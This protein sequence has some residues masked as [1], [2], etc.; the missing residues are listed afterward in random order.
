[1][2]GKTKTMKTKDGR[3]I[4]IIEPENKFI[5][6]KPTKKE[7]QEDRAKNRPSATEQALSD[8]LSERERQK[9]L[10]GLE[11]L[12]LE[13][14]KAIESLIG[15]PVYRRSEGGA[16]EL[17]MKGALTGAGL[18]KIYGKSKIKVEKPKGTKGK[19]SADTLTGKLVR[20]Y[21]VKEKEQMKKKAKDSVKASGLGTGLGE[22]FKVYPSAYKKT[23]GKP[24]NKATGGKIELPK[25]AD[26]DGDGNFNEYETA[27]GEAIQK[28]MAKEKVETASLG[29]AISG[30]PVE[31]FKRFQA[32]QQAKKAEEE[33]MFQEMVK[34]E[35][36]KYGNTQQMKEGGIAKGGGIAIKGLKF[37]GIF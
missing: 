19:G 8:A 18:G 21:S 6:R 7:M 29:R 37:K 13:Q 34:K 12:E 32:D 22:T 15:E 20:T 1:M 36:A 31:M 14:M 9:R 11:G 2:S 17:G 33:K 35:K 30:K 10:E 23:K 25:A 16:L 24:A 4:P 5:K 27:R 3:T 26:L 28:A